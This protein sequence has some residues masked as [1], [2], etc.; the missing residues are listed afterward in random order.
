M[1]LENFHRN[2]M[3]DDIFDIA[4]FRMSRSS[5]FDDFD[6]QINTR[7]K[8]RNFFDDSFFNSDPFFQKSSRAIDFFENDRFEPFVSPFET[9]S[10][11]PMKLRKNNKRR[12]GIFGES[13]NFLEN[14]DKFLSLED[15]AKSNKNSENSKNFVKSS[16][17]SVN[18]KSV[19]NQDGENVT[20]IN[21]KI[22]KDGKVLGDNLKKVTN[23]N[24]ET[25]IT[26]NGDDIENELKDLTINNNPALAIESEIYEEKEEEVEKKS[27]PSNEDVIIEEI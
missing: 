11:L 12:N 16:G 24:G 3:N 25:K 13:N 2:L 18:K 4:P 20:E 6:R 10:L 15:M 26:H 5:I 21:R 19:T 7:P 8:Q 14:I 23:K 22:L 27:H 9:Q 1:L 17:F